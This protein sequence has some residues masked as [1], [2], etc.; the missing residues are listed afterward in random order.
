MKGEDRREDQFEVFSRRSKRQVVPISGARERRMLVPLTAIVTS[1]LPMAAAIVLCAK[2]R[3]TVSAHG[4]SGI[5]KPHRILKLPENGKSVFRDRN[6]A[7]KNFSPIFGF[8]YLR[9]KLL[10]GLSVLSP[11]HFKKSG[12]KL[13]SEFIPE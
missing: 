13:D 11:N 5:Q 10:S 7:K 6:S 2:D 9:L 3:S 8:F 1:S 12:K 4:G